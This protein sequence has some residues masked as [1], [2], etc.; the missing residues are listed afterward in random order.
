[1][2]RIIADS[3]DRLTSVEMR[4]AAELPRG[5]IRPLYE[6]AR[7]VQGDEPLVYLA[8][9]ALL[10]GL[11]RRDVVLIVTGSGSRFGL[12]R[13]ETDGP[14]GAASLG[15]VLDFGLGARTV[16]VCDEHHRGPIVASVEAAG[17]SVL[18]HERFEQRPH[19]ALL[20]IHPPG[21]DAGKAYAAQLLDR[22]Q[23]RAV[24][25][26]EKTGP[27]ARGVH[28]SITGTAKDPSET[29]HAFYLADLARER[30]IV[31]IGVGD[32]GNEIGNGLIYDAARQIQ[33][34]GRRCRCPCEDGVIT[35]TRT[36]VLVSASISNWGAYG[37]AAQV[38]Y[39]LQDPALF[40]DE[41]MEDFMLRRCVAAGGTDGAYAAQILYVDGTSARTQRALVAMLREIVTNGLKKVYRGF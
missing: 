30:G 32:G 19:S 39:T 25:F 34:Y 29:G 3:I 22:Y 10:E 40:Q 6:A 4:F 2:P 26:I 12:S 18:D 13:G 1:M 17:M 35:V 15:R 37:I 33:P 16:Y 27:N 24:V 36:D 11:Q 8:A 23:P 5:V 21:D 31:T 41:E 14:L 9:Q 20:E 28:H 7:D 38:A